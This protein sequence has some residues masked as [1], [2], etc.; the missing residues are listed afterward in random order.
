MNTVDAVDVAPLSTDL[1]DVVS[2]VHE[3]RDAVKNQ[4]TWVS[5]V[6]WVW[7]AWSVFSFVQ[8]S[9]WESKFRYA[10]YY[11]VR[12][13]QITLVKKPHDCDFLKA[14][15]GSKECHFDKV[16]A[17]T[18]VSKDIKTGRPVVSHD[19]GKTWDWDDSTDTRSVPG[20]WVSY[21]KVED[22]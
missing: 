13:E 17:V 3:V 11:N 21:T 22:E 10:A 9:V 6:F 16:V 20:I 2:A 12:N 8:D 5:S 1:D 7:I 14:P 4:H 15:I 19:D 18:K